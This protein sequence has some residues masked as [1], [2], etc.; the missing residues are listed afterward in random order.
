MLVSCEPRSGTIKER[1]HDDL[2]SDIVEWEGESSEIESLS[3]GE[4]RVDSSQD[5]PV[6]ELVISEICAINKS[7]LVDEDGD[8][9]DWG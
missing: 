2:V 7:G 3:D 1:S 9:P 6:R 4:Q 5:E 8:R